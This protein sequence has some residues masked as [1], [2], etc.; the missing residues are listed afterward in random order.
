MTASKLRENVYR[1]LDEVLATGTPVEIERNGRL[2]RIVPVEA[3]P[4][5]ADAARWIER[6]DAI[7]GDIE[8]TVLVSPAVVLE[9]QFLHEIGRLAVGAEEV[10]TALNVQFD[11]RLCPLAFSAVA[12]SALE[13]S[14]TRDPFDRLIV[15]HASAGSHGLVTKDKL[16]HEHFAGA[17][18]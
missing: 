16:I 3:S 5:S 18:W 15:G 14:W 7:T 8:D 13:L 4:G 1:I 6:P 17:S 11:I 12:H 10:A 9:L 2:L